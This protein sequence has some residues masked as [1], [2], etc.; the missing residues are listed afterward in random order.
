MPMFRNP[1]Y[2]SFGNL[3]IREGICSEVMVKRALSYQA[4]N[5]DVRI[6]EALVRL[7]AIDLHQLEVLLA[8]QEV[9]CSNGSGRGIK[10]LANLAIAKVKAVND[11][12]DEILEKKASA[13]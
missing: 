10:R 1:N 5:P 3:L 4:D 13:G 9:A 8:K 2:I 6:G 7:K 12:F 11:T